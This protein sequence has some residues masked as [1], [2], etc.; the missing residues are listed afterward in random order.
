MAEILKGAPA[1]NRLTE[2][3]KIKSE[4]LRRAGVI[5]TLAILRVGE[6]PSDLAYENGA[7]KRCEKAGVAVRNIVLPADCVKD[8][9]LAEIRKINEDP[10]I[11]GCLMFRPLKDK[12]AEAEACELLAAEKDVDSMTRDSLTGVFTGDGTGYPP[13]T[14]QAV[15]ELLK[16]YNIDPSGK[17]AAVVGRSL[18]IGKPVA[19][20]LLAANATVTIC[21]SRTKELASVL[22]DSDIIIAAI[23]SARMLGKDCFR[24]GQVVIDVGINADAEGKLCGDVDFDAA[25]KIAAAVSPVPGGVGSVTTA[26]LCSHVIDAAAASV[27]EG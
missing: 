1:A 25:E 21:H 26:V 4:E 6:D 3:L 27:S 17:K 16:Y 20:L 23:G 15:M 5:P 14:A 9:L 13:C 10:S 22:R 11:H 12:E 2:E 7:V 8:E 19:M 24:E 18:V